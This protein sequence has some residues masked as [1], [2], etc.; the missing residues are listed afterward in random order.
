MKTSEALRETKKHLWSGVRNEGGREFICNAA[1]VAGV[2]R[3]VKPIINRMIFPSSTFTVWLFRNGVPDPTGDYPKLQATRR[4]WLD[5]L[6]EHYES[7]G[8]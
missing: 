3:I 7:L 6:I 1:D 2:A 8:D 5:H 4:A